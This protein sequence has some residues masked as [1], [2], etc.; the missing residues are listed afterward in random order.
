MD[1][2]MMSKGMKNTSPKTGKGKPKMGFMDSKS[3]KY[4]GNIKGGK[5]GGMMAKGKAAMGKGKK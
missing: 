2:K 3:T 1:S 4:T 5:S